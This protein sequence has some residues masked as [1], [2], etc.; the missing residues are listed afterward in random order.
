M[1]IIL[2][3]KIYFRYF[4]IFKFNNFFLKLLVVRNKRKREEELC[5][6]NLIKIVLYL[7]YVLKEI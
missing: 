2:N 7:W 6:C 3:F 4:E 1:F 5:I